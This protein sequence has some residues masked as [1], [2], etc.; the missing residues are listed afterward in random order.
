MT[1]IE[2]L[3]MIGMFVCGWFGAAVGSRFGILGLALGAIAGGAIGI[4]CGITLAFVGVLFAPRSKKADQHSTTIVPGQPTNA[5][6]EPLTTSA[7]PENDIRRLCPELRNI[8]QSELAAG[9]RVCEA[10]RLGDFFVVWLAMPFRHK[11]ADLPPSVEFREVNDP[12]YWKAEY[13][14]H[15]ARQILACKF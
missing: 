15:A 1:L 4:V 11:P 13:V 2:L 7:D 5:N 9:N 10:S 6:Q 3:T 12:H 8:A 14:H